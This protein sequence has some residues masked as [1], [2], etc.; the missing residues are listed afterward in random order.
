MKQVSNNILWLSISRAAG[1][2]LLF[3]AYTQL[4][5]YLGPYKTGQY[6]FVLSL[7]TIFG[8]IIDLGISQY[9]TK[10]IAEDTAQAA[11][12]FYNFLTAE[13]VLAS[14]VYGLMVA[15]VYVRGYDADVRHATMVAG[16]GV[17]LYGLTVP[18]LTVLS[19]F[20]SMRRVA[21]NNF[22]VSLV[23]VL[24]ILSAVY[25]K[26]SIVYLSINQGLASL[27]SLLLYYGHVRAYI[28]NL[29]LRETFWHFDFV[30]LKKILKAAA[31]FA[32][33]VSFSTIYNR[34]DVVLVTKFLG[35]AETG[36]YTTAYKVVDLTNFFPAVVSHSLY[37]ALAALMAKQA[38]GDVRVT[39]EKYMRLMIAV[40]LPLGVGGS[41]LSRQLILVLTSGDARFLPSA[42]VLAILVWAIV[43]LFIYVTA[44]SLVV[45]QL[46]KW[47]VVITGVNVVINIVGNVLLVPH[48]GIQAA[49]WMTVVSEALQGTFYF[50]FIWKNITHFAIIRQFVKPVLAALV[51]GIVLWFLRDWSP[52][53]VPLEASAK[54]L[55][56][57]I[58]NVVIVGGV[59]VCTYVVAL[60]ALKF[61][62]AEDVRFMSK[63]FKRS[64]V[65]ET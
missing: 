6:Q 63:L 5:S 24:V 8:V 64:G 29:R 19:G 56:P 25:F 14:C 38:L 27:C 57:L 26:Y 60:G 21:L 49:A 61:F 45:S 17:L 1:L 42:P 15:F 3:F 22:V 35:Y 30:L 9:V 51:M 44:N 59:G 39:I 43:I 55:A 33:L 34:I 12:Y 54:H 52:F 4:F 13:I 47:A 37:P 32:I 36:L 23:N 11:K 10:K 65:V 41:L 46:T 58:L 40:A 48:Y 7:V 20:Q 62:T 16:L 31:P 2:V 50:Y 18:F 53:L 28:P